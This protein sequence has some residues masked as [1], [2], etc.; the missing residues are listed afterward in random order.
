M[1]YYPTTYNEY[2]YKEDIT[3]NDL[4]D[5][6]NT[7]FINPDVIKILKQLNKEEY[8]KM[9]PYILFL[10]VSDTQLS[11]LKT[12]YD[13]G[14]GI[15]GIDRNKN[16]QGR[17]YCD[18]FFCMDCTKV[19][20][21]YNAVW[22]LSIDLIGIWANNDIL[23]V[24]RTL[25]SE[26]FG[27]Y[28]ISSGEALKMM[29]KVEFNAQNK[30][31][32]PSITVKDTVNTKKKYI[33]KP[34]N[35]S[36][37]QGIKIVSAFDV[38]NNIGVDNIIEEFLEGYELAVNVVSDYGQIYQMGALYRYFNHDE[39]PVPLGGITYNEEIL[40]TVYSAIGELIPFDISCQFKVD[41]LISDGKIYIL[42]MSPRFH[43]E[44]DELIYGED[45]YSLRYFTWK[46]SGD[47]TPIDFTGKYRGY[48]S[49]FN[50]NTPHGNMIDGINLTKYVPHIRNFIKG[51][52]QSTQDITGYALF[53]TDK[54]ISTEQFI[55]I[56]K[57][58]NNEI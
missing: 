32:A 43:G 9:K 53:E 33:V 18:H 58:L 29:N 4:I 3:L 21:I 31:A 23:V 8:N 17:K 28:D 30:Y 19:R 13:L 11:T 12:A 55:K 52:P 49:M 40:E 38:L 10:G 44:V 46:L 26:A 34:V 45:R 5:G 7:P 54:H 50:L 27:L 47:L 14:I 48:F 57:E 39:H 36:G 56:S 24:Y 15:I 42:E 20:E 35:G 37:S 6:E 16:A 25:L 22:A 2:F 51:I 41:V 1:S